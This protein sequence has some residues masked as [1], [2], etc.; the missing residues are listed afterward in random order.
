MPRNE[1]RRK[2]KKADQP[3]D[4]ALL[5]HVRAMGLTTV[6]EYVDWC[7]RHGF[8]RRTDKHPQVLQK[9]R[10]YATRAVAE[11]RFAQKR[12][13]TRNPDLVLEDI[14]AGD[15]HEADLTE[16]HLRAVCR[17]TRAV[18]GTRLGA[19]F[20]D[21]EFWLTVLQFFVAHPMLD[22]AQVGP[23]VDF[24]HHHRFGPPGAARP[25][26]AM[27]DHRPAS[28]LRQVE[29]WHRTLAKVR[30]PTAEWPSS[31]IAAFEFV[32]GTEAGGRLRTWRITELLSTKALVAEGRRM[33]HCVATYDRSCARGVTSIWSLEVET[34]G[35]SAQVLTVELRNRQRLICQAR[36]KCNA[37][38][39]EKHRGIL[40]RWAEQA[41]LTLAQSV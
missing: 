24:V 17:A 28:L 16:P 18:I 27:K 12:R 8:N 31:G 39:A 21:D 19:E 22:P 3:P 14:F 25:D 5:W 41:D 23:I 1:F 37:L 4:P 7:G 40:R 35:E 9:E 13:E 38:P 15:L 26:F 30:R 20:A 11:A 29:A 32:E 36:G 33:K 34:F 6:E 10:D 2:S